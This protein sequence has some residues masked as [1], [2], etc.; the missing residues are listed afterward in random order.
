MVKELDRDLFIKAMEKEVSS[1]FKEE[2][3]K[4]IPKM[5]YYD[6]TPTKEKPEKAS[7]VRKS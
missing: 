1:M 5:R 3:W 4:L 7:R 2:I 6:T